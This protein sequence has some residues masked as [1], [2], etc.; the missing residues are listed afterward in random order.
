MVGTPPDGDQNLFCKMA[1]EIKEDK[2]DGLFL[3][4]P[5]WNNPHVDRE[6]FKKQKKRLIERGE[7]DVFQREYEA[8]MVFGGHRAVFPMFNRARHVLKYESV[9]ADVRRHPKD[10][11]YYYSYDP[12]SRSVF[13]GQAMIINKLTKKA[14]IVDEIYERETRKM[15]AGIIYPASCAQ[16][17]IINP[18]ED[19]WTLV[20]DNAAAWFQTEVLN[21]FDRNMVPCEK[22][23]K[24]KQ[25]KE[26]MI[27][28]MFNYD[29]LFV[30][31]KCVN[32]IS[33][34]E[35]YIIDDKGKTDKC[36]DHEIDNSRYILNVANYTFTPDM[37]IKTVD[38]EKRFYR[39]DEERA[40]D[41]D[42]IYD[43]CSWLYE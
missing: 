12:A 21:Q 1:K 14:I 11:E 37:A 18:F 35:N 32:T 28:D 8:K 3:T 23:I 5:S 7:Y 26:S 30:T 13:A 29:M 41:V 42:P 34:I 39:M 2:Q 22:D 40:S 10:Y 36:A 20:Y 33:E 16:M 19:K 17:E 24:T 4:F 25:N 43:L 15:S 27:K 38:D 6:W 31:D 9:I